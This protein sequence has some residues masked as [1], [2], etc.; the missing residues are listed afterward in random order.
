MVA[1]LTTDISADVTW[2]DVPEV[3]WT[4]T[5]DNVAIVCACLPS[6]GPLLK[7]FLQKVKFN[8]TTPWLKRSGPDQSKSSERSR[9]LQSEQLLNSRT[10][11]ESGFIEL[12]DIGTGED[13]GQ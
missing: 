8:S 9:N 1:L 7:V 12:K 10:K 11:Y 2:E 6:M 3:L 13:S 5:E 4:L